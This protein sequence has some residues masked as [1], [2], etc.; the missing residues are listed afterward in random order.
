[1][2]EETKPKKKAPKPLTHKVLFVSPEAVPFVK[3]GGLGDVAGVLPKYLRRSGCDVRVVLPRYYAVDPQKYK[4]KRRPEALGVPMGPLGEQWCAVYEGKLPG[5]S[6]P[7]YFLEHEGFFGR[8]AV[9]NDPNG[10]GF[11]DNDLRFTFLSRG[12]LQ[13]AKMLEFKPDIVHVNDWQ[14]AGIP[15]ML[16][17]IYKHDEHL[18]GAASVLTIHNL[19]YQ[20]YAFKGLIDVMQVGWDRFNYLELES[21]DQVNLLKGGL[22]H[23]TMINAVSPRYA[24]EI[25]WQRF[26]EGLEGVLRDRHDALRGILNGIDYDEWNPKKD[27]LIKENYSASDLKGKEACKRDLQKAVG[28]KPRKVPV[29]GIVTRLVEQKGIE[30]IAA[31]ME[32]MLH[33]DLQMIILGTGEIWAQDFFNEMARRHP[34]KVACRIGYDNTLAHKIEA[35]SDFF[36][37]PSIFEPC[38]LNQMYSMSYGTPPIVN[39]VGGLDDTVENFDPLTHSGTGF[40]IYDLT[41]ASLYDTVGWAVHTFFNDQPALEKLRKRCMKQRFTWKKAAESYMEMYDEAIRRKRG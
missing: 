6:V 16:N 18:G 4:L 31:A 26:G 19:K 23:A 40:K 36:L 3:T 22:Y 27:P 15:V 24:T 25:L 21:H 17:T 5:S 7:V 13:L 11:Q 28:L 32:R 29:F 41:P 10:H 38:G 12:A 33:M 35:G 20:G 8:D 30:V 14:T 2:T 34:E 1:M 37:M 39:A 9:Y